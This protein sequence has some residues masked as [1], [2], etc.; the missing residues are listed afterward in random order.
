MNSKD[1]TKLGE[2]MSNKNNMPLNVLTE[3]ML[4]RGG[5]NAILP[6][7]KTDKSAPNV[8]SI[9]N[10]PYTSDSENPFLQFDWHCPASVAEIVYKAKAPTVFYIHGG[11][12]SSADKKIYSRLSKDFAEQ[13][14]VVINMNFRLMPE[15]DLHTH[16]QDCIACIKYCLNK[17]DLFGIDRKRVF[18]AG[19]SSGAHMASLIGARIND[20]KIS[21]NCKIAGLLLFYGIYDLNHLETVHFR[22]CNKLHNGF[23]NAFG[24]RLKRFYRDYSPTT[25]L[26]RHFPPCFITAGEVDGLHTESIMLSNLLDEYKVQHSTLI[27]PKNRKDGRHAFVNL[28]NNARAE[29]LNQMF[30]F[31]REKI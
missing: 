12:W 26:S 24:E 2:F 3:L 18:F 28:M 19:D 31:M 10:I 25:Y 6:F 27:F 30:E 21:I 1:K 11:A 20:N 23:K 4:N 17:N 16:Y 5:T 15:Y 14:F 29:A 7:I 22:I 13:G 8:R 9:Y